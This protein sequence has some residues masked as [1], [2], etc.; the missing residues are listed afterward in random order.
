M[1]RRL[2][3]F[4]F[5]FCQ[6]SFKLR[7]SDRGSPHTHPP[8]QTQPS[9]EPSYCF[10][11]FFQGQSHLGRSC[12]KLPRQFLLFGESEP[13]RPSQISHQLGSRGVHEVLPAS[14]LKDVF[15][16]PSLLPLLSVDKETPSFRMVWL[17]LTQTHHLFF[18]LNQ[19][20][21]LG[22]GPFRYCLSYPILKQKR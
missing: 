7:G 11:L 1:F 19:Y 13:T 21:N 10:W 18:E 17:S 6:A 14:A 22:D 2:S 3:F 16:Y 5:F 12:S 15:P 20:L 8:T 4:V 9:L